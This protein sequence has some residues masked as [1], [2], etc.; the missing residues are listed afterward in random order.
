VGHGLSTLDAVAGGTPGAAVPAAGAGVAHR[1]TLALYGT[2]SFVYAFFT[3]YGVLGLGGAASVAFG[4]Y[5]WALGIAAISY[6]IRTRPA[7][8]LSGPLPNPLAKAAA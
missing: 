6:Q 4:G 2:G 1:P 7:C 8:D 5:G 3:D